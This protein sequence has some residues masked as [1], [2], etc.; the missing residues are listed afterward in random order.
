MNDILNQAFQ[1]D[2]QQAAAAAAAAVPPITPI[3][4]PAPVP[5]G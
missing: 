4:P 1:W 2:K 3:A 5:G